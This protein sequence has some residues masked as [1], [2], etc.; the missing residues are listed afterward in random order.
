[1]PA[2]RE[3]EEKIQHNFHIQVFFEIDFM[4]KLFYLIYCLKAL[5]FR[6]VVFFPCEFIGYLNFS[7][8]FSSGSMQIAFQAYNPQTAQ[9]Y[10][11]I[12]KELREVP[13]ISPRFV[14]MF[15]PQHGFRGMKDTADFAVRELG[16]DKKEVM[17][18]W[19]TYWRRFDG[20]V[21]SDVYAK[22]PIVRARK[23]LLPH[24][25][26]LLSRWVTK[27]PLRKSVSDFDI[28]LTCGEFDRA[29]VSKYI[30]GKPSLQ[31]VGFPFVD[32]LFQVKPAS[33][34]TEA[35]LPD[36]GRKTVLYGPSWG[37]PY[38]YGDILSRNIRDVMTCLREK[39]VDVLLKLHAASFYPAQS[40][41]IS[42]RKKL[43]EY[44]QWENVTIITDLSDIPA[45]KTADILITDISSRSFNFMITDRPVIIYGVP[46]R[47]LDTDIERYRMEKISGGA[48]FASDHYQLSNF[49]DRC[50]STPNEMSPARKRVV[51]DLF[52][53][54]GCAAKKTAACILREAGVNR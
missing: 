24:G 10:L 36:T 41:G 7:P 17:P 29:Q 51:E 23:I 39:D 48:Y 27:H 34:A 11:P 2:S 50:V 22:F 8:F 4:Q 5:I 28:Y 49:I 54:P 35:A 15:H 47:Y 53:H 26:G 6:A 20:L 45:M 46:G 1:M 52:A 43:A 42:W 12:L 14:V 38:A 30:D 16:F 9:I 31:V 25:A 3:V 37:H 13:G 32:P 21:C 44:G 33:D 18:V 19:R 40:R